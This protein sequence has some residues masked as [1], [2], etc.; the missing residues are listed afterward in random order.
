MSTDSKSGERLKRIETS[1][2]PFEELP[3]RRGEQL[4]IEEVM[5]HLLVPGCSLAIIEDGRIVAAEG[6][7]LTSPNG[8]APVISSTI[9]QACSISKAAAGTG[10]M[11]LVQE[12]HLA[13]DE[14]INDYLTSW[15]VPANNGWQPRVTL[16]HLLTHT[17]GFNYSWFPGYQQ[18]EPTPTTLQT[19]KGEHPA[20]TPP[21]QV[22]GLPGAE[23]SYSGAHYAVLQ[24]LM[25]EVTGEA[26]PALMQRLIFDPLGMQDSSY[27]QVFP[28][29]RPDAV[30]LGHDA[31]GV[32]L[33]G[34]WHIQP[35][36]AG[37]GLWT[38]PADLCLL[39]IAVQTALSG[40]NSTFLD[41]E[42]ATAML[43][44]G[45]GN[46]GLGWRMNVGDDWLWFEHGGDNVGYK[47]TLHA[48]TQQGRGMAIMTNGDAGQLAYSLVATA[49]AREYG[50][51]ASL[52]SNPTE[53]FR[54]P[55]LDVSS[56]LA[57]VLNTCAGKYRLET[58]LDLMIEV[59]EGQFNLRAGDQPPMQLLPI[60]EMTFLAGAVNATITFVPT[61]GETIDS[62]RFQ[63]FGEELV[64][65]RLPA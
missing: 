46:R 44:P 3:D 64:G 30:A 2:Q 1:V 41:R 26:F 13:L 24:L 59:H 39:A 54:A 27:D 33:A 15:Q 25:E 11:R 6:Y 51:P 45:P 56:S 9:F 31:A 4:S 52:I 42:H 5:D 60:S 47:C 14:D 48:D 61:S 7:G 55:P 34:G 57:D 37:A 49:I 32:S 12:G 16:R 20:N 29:T 40:E 36:Y 18:G 53:G 35:E 50:W 22:T 65:E 43:T 63:Q 17:A 19:I 10:A 62:L 8:G 23:F 28:D 21:I 38:T 58:G